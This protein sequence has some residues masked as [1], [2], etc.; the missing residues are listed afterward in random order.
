MARFSPKIEI[1]DHFENLINRIDIDIDTCLEKYNNEQLLS[2]LLS[3][4]EKHR[5]KFIRNHHHFELNFFD[6]KTN[7]SSEIKPESVE[8]VKVVDYLKTIRMRTIEKLRKAQEETLQC[9]KHNSSRF[10]SEQINIDELK[11]EL[12]FAEKKFKFVNR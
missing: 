3:S 9:Y 4:S 10:K 6:K 5:K 7:D 8:S 1:I 11:S 12:F 2:E